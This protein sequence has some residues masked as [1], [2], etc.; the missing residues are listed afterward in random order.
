MV[1][2]KSYL[3]RYV[4][5][6]LIPIEIFYFNPMLIKCS[7]TNWKFLF[8][9][10]TTWRCRL[11]EWFNKLCY[12]DSANKY[13]NHNYSTESINNNNECSKMH[14]NL[15]WSEKQQINNSLP[16]EP[17]Q[18]SN[19]IENSLKETITTVYL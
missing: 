13:L 1:S 2:E 10:Q 19:L 15:K 17:L 8:W 9:E 5:K 14:T 3:D 11:S 6:L 4:L 7:N 12:I 16:K 18:G